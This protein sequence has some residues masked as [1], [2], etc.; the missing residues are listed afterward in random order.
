MIRHASHLLHRRAARA[1]RLVITTLVATVLTPAVRPPLAFAQGQLFALPA[2][3]M[4]DDHRVAS[5]V[6]LSLTG[7][8]VAFESD[9]PLLP[10]DR[11]GTTDIY[12]LDR[13]H[14]DLTLVS[15]AVSGAAADAPSRHP[16]I[17]DDGSV[18][19]FESVGRNLTVSG[20][21][22]SSHVYVY[23]RSSDSIKLATVNAAGRPLDGE[24]GGA[25]IAA[26]GDVLALHSNT[27]DP[28]W[29]RCAGARTY[30]V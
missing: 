13:A 10:D 6:A 12:L 19:A 20:T 16:T 3:E 8:F 22:G 25:R 24:N 4:R 15:R 29:A 2:G 9:A 1:A 14:G 27:S 18:L 23:R 17:S 11:N 26:N 5:S 30:Q 28:T 7:R 21:S